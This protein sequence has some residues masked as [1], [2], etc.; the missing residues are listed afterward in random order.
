MNSS[1][2]VFSLKGPNG[3]EKHHFY[4]I[5]NDP[6]LLSGDKIRKVF[7]RNFFADVSTFLLIREMFLVKLKVLGMASICVKFYGIW[8]CLAL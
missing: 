3:K 1:S 5:C 2:T 6:E 4:Q 8:T 7:F